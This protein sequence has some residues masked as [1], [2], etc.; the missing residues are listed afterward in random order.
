MIPDQDILVGAVLGA[1][2]GLLAIRAS[3]GAAR[4]TWRNSPFAGAAVTAFLAALATIIAFGAIL[5]GLSLTASRFVTHWQDF[6]IPFG[7]GFLG[8]AVIGKLLLNRG[9]RDGNALDGVS[10]RISPVT[11]IQADNGE[12]VFRRDEV[13]VRAAPLIGFAE[14]GKIFAVGQSA[15]RANRGRLVRLFEPDARIDEEALRAFCRYHIMLMSSSSFALRPRVEIV[16]RTIRKASVRMPP[17]LS[18]EL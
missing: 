18:K 13:E 2:A 12:L 8:G 4:W 15:E 7:Y 11:T 9:R 16:E 10:L 1:M 3:A 6:R 14:D 17:L 5:L